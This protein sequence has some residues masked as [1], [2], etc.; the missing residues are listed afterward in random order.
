MSEP[1]SSPDLKQDLVDSFDVFT[2]QKGK[3]Y[4]QQS[5]VV[6]YRI[7]SDGFTAWVEA[8]VRGSNGYRLIIEITQDYGGYLIDGHCSCQETFNCAHAAA[9]L[10]EITQL[11]KIPEALQTQGSDASPL[12]MTEKLNDQTNQWLINFVTATATA[13]TPIKKTPEEVLV[14]VFDVITLYHK[15]VLVITTEICRKLKD[16][17]LGK[18]YPFV[19]DSVYKKARISGEELELCALLKVFSSESNY[20]NR[21]C[22]DNK[23]ISRLLE[24]LLATHK[25]Y[26]HS[27]RATALVQGEP[28]LAHFSW[29]VDANS[30]Q[31]I[32]CDLQSATCVLL[33]LTP[34]WYIDNFTQQMGVVQTPMNEKAACQLLNAPRLSPFAAKQIQQHLQQKVTDAS[35]IPLPMA[36]QTI[37]QE[38][39]PPIPCLHI[40]SAML[41]ASNK[42]FY[43]KRDESFAVAAL[44]F[45]YGTQQVP[46]RSNT[47]ILSELQGEVLIS[48]SR[49]FAAETQLR[50]AFQ[51][52]AI[53]VISE[54]YHS[55]YLSVQQNQLTDHFVLNKETNEPYLRDFT[56]TVVP[57]LRQAGWKISFDRAYPYQEIVQIDEWYGELNETTDYD[58]FNLE[59]GIMIDNQRVSLLAPLLQLIKKN[60]A[61]TLL[62]E[63]NLAPNKRMT[64]EISPGK[65]VSVLCSR[66]LPILQVLYELHTPKAMDEAKVLRI[67]R[68]RAGLLTDM[69]NALVA[70]ELRWFGNQSLRELGRRLQ[71][72]SG[73]A[74]ATMPTSLNATLRPYQVEGVSWLQFL[75]E[76]QLNGVLADDMGLG[77]TVQTLAHLLIEK[78]SGRLTKPCLIIAPTS[79]IANWF[80]EAERF[81]PSLRVLLLHGQERKAYFDTIEDYD[82]IL[83]TYPLLIRDTDV[84]MN[85]AF[86]FI[87]LD[88]AQYIKN[89]QAKMTQI[90]QQLSADHRLCLTGTPMENHL[91]ELWSLYHFLMPGLLGNQKT[92]N[93]RYRHPIEK[94]GDQACQKQ[95]NNMIK[96]FLLRRTKAQVME[97]L[98]AKTEI[99]HRVE[100]NAKQRD[101]YESIRLA[102][103]EKVKKAI[104]HQGIDRCQIIILDA[105]LKLRQVCCDPR[106]VKLA[107]AKQVQQSAKL[108]ALLELLVPMIAEGRRILLFSQFTSML[109]LIEAELAQL[110]IPYLVLTGQTKERLPLIQAFQA[111]EVPLFLIS[112]KAG[113]TGL[114]LT[115]ADTVIHYDPWWNP[116]VESQ[117]TDR[118]HRIGQEKAVFVYKLVTNGTVEEKIL[119]MQGKKKALMDAIFSEEANNAKISQE[120][121]EALFQ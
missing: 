95:L 30:E 57:A 72:F 112:L 20:D 47:K 97:D 7:T 77:K 67:S 1:I 65:F 42:H 58:W 25:C 117:A 111:E 104:D 16:G 27:N 56:A 38:N 88:E 51:T 71:D 36:Y 116:A 32:Q 31:T 23:N 21:F 26:W 29:H 48:M 15:K 106:L 22:F 94:N 6:N 8:Q 120:D 45:A 61:A 17:R 18:A 66:M 70:S 9:V 87:I 12:V 52:N 91:G 121:F 107:S 68:L 96:P 80:I 109:T 119:C 24:R 76:Y 49:D 98:P 3:K 100:L 19:P 63:L 39:I 2:L 85:T 53:K 10:F 118:A 102:M 93:Q 101:L 115:A 84:L 103:H 86:Y 82:L 73:I 41:P 54:L 60:A 11:E 69:E 79:V 105:L 81:A 64:L 14:F 78:A 37:Q 90:V 46:W 75:R 43:G 114:N 33:P 89:A 108:V 5:Q 34:L 55:Y 110:K 4:Q 83:T 74:V 50:K 62:A 44:H 113:G 92:F 59:L 13:E 35:H 28:K 99:I 40:F